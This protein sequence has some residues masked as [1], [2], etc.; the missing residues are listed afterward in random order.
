MPNVIYSETARGHVQVLLPSTQQKRTDNMHKAGPRTQTLQKHSESGTTFTNQK[1]LLILP[2]SE[3][4]GSK[5][6]ILIYKM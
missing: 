1:A 6:P 4:L 2:N 5:G 3:R